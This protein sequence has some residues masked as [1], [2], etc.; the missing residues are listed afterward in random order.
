MASLYFRYGAMNCGKTVSLLQVA[1][2]YEEN[3]LKVVLLKPSKDTKGEGKVVSRI[4]VERNA[5]YL[6][7]EDEEILSHIEKWKEE[8]VACILVDEA[9]FLQPKQIVELHKISKFYDIPVICYGIRTNYRGEPFEGSIQLMV[10]ADAIEKYVNL[11]SCGSKAEFQGRKVNGEFVVEG[12]E[13]LIDGSSASVEYVPLCGKCFLEKVY[14]KIERL[15]TAKP[16]QLT[17]KK[18]D[19]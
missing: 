9:E 2:N 10:W 1:H 17:L 14:S 11:C 12:E 5:D 7:A 3:G 18:I 15:E 6:I 16:K 4:G 13:V 8:N 19:Y